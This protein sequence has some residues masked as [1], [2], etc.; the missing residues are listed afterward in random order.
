MA[1]ENKQEI[2]IPYKNI[3]LTDSINKYTIIDNNDAKN[4]N[5]TFILYIKNNKTLKKYIL[6]IKNEIDKSNGKI[7][8]VNKIRLNDTIT[9]NANIYD[10]IMDEK[11]GVV[12]F[13]IIVH[14]LFVLF[15]STM[16]MQ[17]ISKMYIR[18]ET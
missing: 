13:I 3:I 9:I 8:I 5:D 2:I 16:T 18:K 17:M 1:I 4:E 15:I 14:M 10:Y 7:N 12:V 11:I 6:K